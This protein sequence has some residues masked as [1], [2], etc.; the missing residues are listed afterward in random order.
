MN[1]HLGAEGKNS[2][3]NGI[4]KDEGINLVETIRRLQ[5]Y[6]KIHKSYNQRLI[7]DKE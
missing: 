7:K 4:G 2:N 6:V 3:G 5:T 1:F